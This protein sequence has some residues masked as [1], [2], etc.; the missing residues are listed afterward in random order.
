MEPSFFSQTFS[1]FSVSLF[2]RLSLPLALPFP[3]AESVAVS[4]SP[5]VFLLDVNVAAAKVVKIKAKSINIE[6]RVSNF[7]GRARL[8]ISINLILHFKLMQCQMYYNFD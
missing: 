2:S 7:M 4:V 6:S 3:F 5:K 1:F 8:N